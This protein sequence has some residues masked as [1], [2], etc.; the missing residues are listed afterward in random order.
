MNTPFTYK[1]TEKTYIKS[2]IKK[3]I[4]TYKIFYL[5]YKTNIHITK[6]YKTYK[7]IEWINIFNSAI[8]IKEIDR[9]FLKTTAAKFNINYE[10]LKNKFYK[11][12]KIHALKDIELNQLFFTDQRGKN[13]NL[14]INDNEKELFYYLNLNYILTNNMKN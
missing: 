7:P 10:T 2:C 8:A 5:L 3:C 6:C 11:Y 4:K 14:L 13:N 1:A 9:N 12:N